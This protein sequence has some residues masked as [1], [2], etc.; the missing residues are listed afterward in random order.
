MQQLNVDEILQRALAHHQAGRLPEAEQG[1]RQILAANPQHGPTLH[2][3]GVLAHQAGRSD[4]AVQMISQAI[5]FGVGGD[6]FNNLGEAYRALGK[7]NEAVAAYQKAIE[8]NPN[9][10]EAMSNLGLVL[11]SAGRFK[12]ALPLLERAIALKPNLPNAHFNYGISLDNTGK[13]DDAIE[14]W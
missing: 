10:A 12:E 3:F 7:P 5:Q 11:N 6:A 4:L 8:Q 1:Y 9:H 13:V 2:L 14:Q